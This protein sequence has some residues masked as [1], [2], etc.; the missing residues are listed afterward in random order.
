MSRDCEARPM[1]DESPIAQ[2]NQRRASDSAGRYWRLSELK[3][4]GKS[5]PDANL[6]CS[7]DRSSPADSYR[8]CSST[9]DSLMPVVN[10]GPGPAKLPRS[11]S[12][13][14]RA[15]GRRSRREQARWWLCI[16]AWRA[17]IPST[18]PESPKYSA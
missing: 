9:M 11:V 3:E 10:F 17:R 5:S 16:P 12:P 7:I 2:T 14:E 6:R 4:S 1:G 15:L 8:P 13:R 18:L